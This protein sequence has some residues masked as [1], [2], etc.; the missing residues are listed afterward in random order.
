MT[1]RKMIISKTLTL[2]NA[3][4]DK[5][6]PDSIL[7]NELYTGVKDAIKDLLKVFE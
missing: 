2:L 7:T 6:V 5:Y 1:K 3:R 4:L